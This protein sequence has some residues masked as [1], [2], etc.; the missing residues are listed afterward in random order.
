MSFNR[1]RLITPLFEISRALM[2][3]LENERK[4]PM[5]SGE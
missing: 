5:V 4:R 1:V 3:R 2:T